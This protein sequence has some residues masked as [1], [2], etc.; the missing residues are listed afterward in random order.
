MCK[1]VAA[2]RSNDLGFTYP[3]KCPVGRPHALF[4]TSLS[5]TYSS[6]ITYGYI[7]TDVNN[8]SEELRVMVKKM[9]A[10]D[11]NDTEGVEKVKTVCVKELYIAKQ[12]PQ[13]VVEGLSTK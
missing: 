7:N 8:I 2:M 9:N 4:R 11:L 1:F 13:D 5:G 6:S 12:I 10:K 3:I